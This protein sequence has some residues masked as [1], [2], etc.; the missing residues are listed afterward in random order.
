M[1]DLL[2]YSILLF[3]FGVDGFNFILYILSLRGRAEKNHHSPFLSVVIPAYNSAH[4]LEW[5]IAS[6]KQSLYENFEIIVVDDGSTDA[7][8][9]ILETMDGVRVVRRA[10]SG[11]AAALNEGVRQARGDIVTIDADTFVDREAL[12]FLASGLSRHDAVGGN[13]RVLHGGIL[14]LCQAAE[15]VRAGMFRRIAA[16]KGEVDIVPGPLGAYRRGIFEHLLFQSSLVEDF[17]MASRMREA[18]F[19]VG[20]EPRALAYTRMPATLPGFLRQ[21]GRW[22]YGNLDLALRGK[23]P[24]KK[25]IHSIFLAALDLLVLLLSL[26]TG[27]YILLLLFFIFEGA[28]MVTG[29]LKEKGGLG[30]S[31]LLFPLF[32]WFLDAVILVTYCLALIRFAGRRGPP[33]W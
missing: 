23:I 27:N 33:G 6:V 3:V 8:R 18:G 30:L 7:T 14:P 5:C 2:L 26:V 21:R 20:Y 28:S 16:R 32:M 13:L 22:A 11:K 17:D 24:K 31:A 25:I 1:I 19:S 12:S 10:H 9:V 4:T 29:D 15:H